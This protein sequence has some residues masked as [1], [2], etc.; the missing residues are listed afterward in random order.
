MK[1][2]LNCRVSPAQAGWK[3]GGVLRAELGLSK[4][5]LVRLKHLS[6]SVTADGVPVRMTDRAAAGMESRM[7]SAKETVERMGEEALAST[8]L[9][10]IFAA[11]RSSP[12]S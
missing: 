4:T 3:I 1:R 12:Y 2:I 7:I 6:G 5:Q 10:A 11:N 9:F 8:I